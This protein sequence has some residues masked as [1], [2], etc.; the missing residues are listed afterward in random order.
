MH[1]AK[2]YAEEAVKQTHHPE[3]PQHD[4]NKNFA[5]RGGVAKEEKLVAPP[6]AY[7]HELDQE[8]AEHIASSPHLQNRAQQGI[9]PLPNHESTSRTRLNFEI[10][11]P[12]ST[13]AVG[14]TTSD[15]PFAKV[16]ED[17]HRTDLL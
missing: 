17:A 16:G 9:L 7:T 5:P 12:V 6:P 14:K 1:S 4:G 8:M 13:P 15:N 2:N 11:D 10:T 3:E